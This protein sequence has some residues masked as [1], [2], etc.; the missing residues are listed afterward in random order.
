MVL[1]NINSNTTWRKMLP[2]GLV[3]MQEDFVLGGTF[4]SEEQ[5]TPER[6]CTQINRPEEKQHHSRH[7]DLLF[8]PTSNS[9]RRDNVDHLDH[10]PPSVC[11]LCWQSKPSHHHTTHWIMGKQR[12][13]GRESDL[14]SDSEP[15]NSNKL[16][17]DLDCDPSLICF[18][19]NISVSVP[20]RQRNWC[21]SLKVSFT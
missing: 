13:R 2:A 20:I 1:G 17:S 8:L 12:G 16:A 19:F 5:V 18:C 15:L 4:S 14:P 21:W 11:H 10:D 7:S 3:H 9:L 6:S